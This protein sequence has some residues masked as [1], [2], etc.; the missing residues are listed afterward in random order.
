VTQNDLIRVVQDFSDKIAEHGPDTVAMIYYAG[1]GVQVAG[2][3]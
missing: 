1:H 3:N 2:E